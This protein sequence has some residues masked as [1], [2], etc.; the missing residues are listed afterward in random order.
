MIIR[1]CSS[2]WRLSQSYKTFALRT[3]VL[4]TACSIDWCCWDLIQILTWSHDHTS[5]HRIRKLSFY[6]VLYVYS[7]SL[8]VQPSL[9]FAL[10]PENAPPHSNYRFYLIYSLLPIRIQNSY[11]F[12]PSPSLGHPSYP[13]LSNLIMFLSLLIPIRVLI[14]LPPP[15]YSYDIKQ[16]C[17][18]TPL[19]HSVHHLSIALLP[20]NAP[21]SNQSFNL[22]YLPSPFCY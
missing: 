13:L 8:L 1:K 9:S 14:H 20:D 12:T 2:C 10:P 17:M 3:R 4:R 22:F 7:P 18:F 15:P 6:V 19:V 11:V 5:I 21:H 16:F